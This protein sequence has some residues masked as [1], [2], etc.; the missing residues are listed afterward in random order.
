[1]AGG[2][3]TTHQAFLKSLQVLAE[4]QRQLIEAKC[5]GF[6]TDAAASAE[7]RARASDD[8]RFFC[9]TY[10]PHYCQGPESVL[11]TFV[12]DELAPKLK[13]PGGHTEAIAAPRG[14]GKSTTG[15]KLLSVWVIVQALKHYGLIIMDT[16]EQ[17]QE[18]L[19]GVKVELAFNPRL[20][21][22]YPDV[23]GQGAVWRAGCMV[24]RNGI[25]FLAA[26]IRK[27]VRG[28][29]HGPYRPDFVIL[30]DLE[31]DE[32]VRSKEY[33]DKVWK[34]IHRE[35]LEVGPPDGSMN[36]FYWG[37]VL[38]YDSVLNR[39][40]KH[41]LW[42]GRRFQSIIQW[43]D[44][45]ELWER[46][47]EF[48]LNDSEAVADRFYRAHK[49]AMD[50]GAVVSWG[51]VRSLVMLM[52]KRA[53]D[54]AAFDAEQQNSPGNDELAPFRNITFWVQPSRHWIYYGSVDPSLGKHNKARD[55]SAILVGGYDRTTGVL[56]VVEAHIKRRLPD[57]L[58]SEVIE[59][60]RKYRCVLWRFESVQ[61]Q[62]FLRTE[63][64]KR[65]AAMG[66]P[67][68]A[69][70]HIPHTDKTLRIES[71][72]PHVQNK[73]IRLHQNQTTLIEQLRYWPEADHDDGPDAL[74]MLWNLAISQAGGLL[75][76]LVTV[77]GYFSS[78]F[79]D[80]SGYDALLD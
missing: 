59:L 66:V 5:L 64:V 42:H 50:R 20:A 46:W 44:D 13:Q 15:V 54:H 41:P 34:R 14:E 28:L 73:L 65:S 58:I 12:Y 67:V 9:L 35:V 45:M 33:R 10:F 75:S 8:F 77:D 36:V 72:Q 24:S 31:N 43:P 16:L 79:T 53:K 76:H 37:T 60:Q 30:D 19:E 7:R 70:P 25:K 49:A 61:F 47:E 27:K 2:R 74:E 52:K 32:N 68:P 3:K 78:P 1:M 22:D 55:P 6:A 62:E 29:N 18:M 38:H 48:L 23:C 40:L 80:Y 26:S 69:L 57:T 17:S 56:D 39:A 63:L 11:H 4:E 21:Q 71:L 51:A